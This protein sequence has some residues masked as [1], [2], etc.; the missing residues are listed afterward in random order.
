MSICIV[1]NKSDTHRCALCEKK[2]NK[3]EMKLASGGYKEVS[4]YH[5]LC[6]LDFLKK[7]E[8]IKKALSDN[9]KLSK[10]K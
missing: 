2:F 10:K 6:L 8:V 1:K 7:S 4:Y 5:I 9:K 3:G